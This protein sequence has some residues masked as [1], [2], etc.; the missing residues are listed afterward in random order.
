MKQAHITATGM[1]V[2]ERLVTNEDLAELV[3]TSDEWIRTRTGMVQRYVSSPEEASSDLAL[4]AS[5]NALAAAGLQPN[6]IDAI[7]LGTITPDYIFPST[8][9][10]LQSRLGITNQC[11]AF[12]LSAACTGFIYTLSVADA[13]IRAGTFQR[14]LVVGVDMLTKTVNWEDRGTA[15]LF[16]DGA[17]AAIVEP[18]EDK[19]IIASALHANGDLV[20]LLYQ[21]GGGSRCPMSQ[22]AL[23]KNTQYIVVRGREIYRHATQGMPEVTLEALEKAGKSV[24]DVALI[25]PHQANL[26]IIEA[27]AKRL[28]LPLEKFYLN[29]QKYANT[30]AA[31]VPM[32]THEAL[33]DG[34]IKEGDL[35]VMVSFG[36]GLTWG[37]NVVQF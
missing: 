18:S 23:D 4:T 7:I 22:E 30:S 26:R 28:D 11:A 36:A 27:V 19:G 29:I 3:D 37:A 32:A 15:V 14:I 5:Q 1:A 35:V 13:F 20:D 34:S 10:V 31:T 2:P 8:A 12:D 21:P 25:V 6:D 17:G 33:E 16:G 24:E 9:C